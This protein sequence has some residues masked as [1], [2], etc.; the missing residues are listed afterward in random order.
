[1]CVCVHGVCTRAC[2]HVTYACLCSC[3]VRVFVF[4]LRT[5]LGLIYDILEFKN[6]LIF[7]F[8]FL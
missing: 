5:C 7:F 4:M 1:M 2:V 8:R 3:Y 6:V